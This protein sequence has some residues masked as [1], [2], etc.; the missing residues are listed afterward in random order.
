M[1]YHIEGN[2]KAL[3]EIRR[4]LSR[5]GRLCFIEAHQSVLRKLYD[6]VT[7]SPIG[8][9][10]PYLRKR[11]H[12]YLVEKKGIEHWQKYEKRFLDTLEVQGFHRDFVRPDILSIIGQFQKS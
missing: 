10:I 8:S 5:D 6:R 2:K 4:M 1:F 9:S 3:R 12:A 7:F 11:K